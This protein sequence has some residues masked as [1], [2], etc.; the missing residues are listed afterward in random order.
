M[1]RRCQPLLRA[2]FAYLR[3]LLLTARSKSYVH[4]YTTPL[5]RVLTARRQRPCSI[6][7]NRALFC[8]YYKIVRRTEQ[9]PYLAQI[10]ISIRNF[11]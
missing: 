5:L 4:T 8:Q 3:L 11:R 6:S 1:L 7:V 2:Y 10:I 9:L